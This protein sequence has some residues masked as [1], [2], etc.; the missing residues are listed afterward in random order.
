MECVYDTDGDRRR[1]STVDKD[2]KNDALDNL[3]T[4]IRTAPENEVGTIVDQLRMKGSLAATFVSNAKHDKRKTSNE[5]SKEP[6]RITVQDMGKLQ[7]DDL[8]DLRHFGHSSS[9]ECI[10]SW[11]RRTS[12]VP[13]EHVTTGPL[14]TDVTSDSDLISELLVSLSFKRDYLSQVD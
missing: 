10:H 7:A 8:G 3:V 13:A 2:R 11:P 12:L 4:R 5:Y 6:E 1:K 9:L 14:W